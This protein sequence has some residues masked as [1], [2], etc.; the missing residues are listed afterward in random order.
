M[1]LAM[2]NNS[3]CGS[4]HSTIHSTPTAS[5]FDDLQLLDDEPELE[6]GQNC[7]DDNGNNTFDEGFESVLLRRTSAAKSG[8]QPKGLLRQAVGAVFNNQ[9][10]LDST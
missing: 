5:I 3:G 1:Q 4:P 9:Y 8:Q 10:S 2:E 6:L 7:V